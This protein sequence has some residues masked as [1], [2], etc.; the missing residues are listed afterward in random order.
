M[1]QTWEIAASPM[2]QVRE[3]LADLERRR[4]DVWDGSTD[5]PDSP[6]RVDESGKI[7]VQADGIVETD[8][9]QALESRPKPLRRSTSTSR[10]S[11]GSQTCTRTWTPVSSSRPSSS[12]ARSRPDAAVA[13]QELPGADPATGLKTQMT[14]FAVEGVGHDPIRATGAL[15]LDLRPVVNAMTAGRPGVFW[16]RPRAPQSKD[17]WDLFKN[18]AQNRNE[19]VNALYDTLKVSDDEMETA[20]L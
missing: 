14:I 18:A 13:R 6:L 7:W 15:L 9:Q 11:R 1:S 19:D 2:S 10:M 3:A 17:P 12:S 4:L 5:E 8:G 16:L 20:I